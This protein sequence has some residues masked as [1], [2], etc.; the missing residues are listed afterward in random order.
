MVSNN[1]SMRRERSRNK[2]LISLR[3]SPKRFTDLEK[4]TN[5]SAAGLNDI[6]IIL[7][8]E[9]IIESTLLDGKPAYKITK[10]GT[11]ALSKYNSLSFDI[12]EIKSRDGVYQRDYS[13]LNGGMI[14]SE[15]QWGIRSDLISD[16]P[17]DKLNL[18]SSS[19]V[20]DLEK[21]LY[22]KLKHNISKSKISENKIGEM[23]LGFSISLP[24]VLESIKKK[25]LL[26]YENMSKEEIKILNKLSD[27]ERLTVPEKKRLETLRKQTQKKIISLSD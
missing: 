26:Y 2:V 10:K 25:S 3:N 11:N 15:L 12:D 18:L 6:R 23:V 5:L 24:K 21:F 27:D 9:K 7:L 16:K 13:V 4:E 14:T 19:D 8:E 1:I 22:D 17:I 20:E